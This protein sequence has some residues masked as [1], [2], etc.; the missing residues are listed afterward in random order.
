M[1]LW[2]VISRAIAAKVFLP[3]FFRM[4]ERTITMNEYAYTESFSENPLEPMAKKMITALRLIFWGTLICMID[5]RINQF[6]IINNFIGMILIMCGVLSLS[7]IAVSPRYSSRMF[8]N[9]VMVVLATIASFF[10]AV[11]YPL[12]TSTT[13]VIHHVT[14]YLFLQSFLTLFFTWGWYWFCLC[15]KEMCDQRHVPRCSASW[16]YSS[17][18]IFYFFFIPNCIGFFF[19]F[20]LA[21]AGTPMPLWGHHDISKLNIH[22]PLVPLFVLLTLTLIALVSWGVIHFLISLSRMI[23]AIQNDELTQSLIEDF[24]ETELNP[25]GVSPR[26]N[27]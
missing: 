2:G 21:V 10:T 9:S 16:R 8:Y 14:L 27:I 22:S 4:T 20:C 13:F 17:N 5:V 26:A 19:F 25:P 15:M 12:S 3:D 24:D 6:D 11:V 23:R 7:K 1:M 18:L